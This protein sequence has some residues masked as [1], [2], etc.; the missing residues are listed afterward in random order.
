MTLVKSITKRYTTSTPKAYLE[1]IG[2]YSERNLFEIYGNTPI[3]RDHEVT[4]LTFQERDKNPTISQLHCTILDDEDSFSLRDEDSTNG[5][6]LNGKKLEPLAPERLHDGDV[7]EIGQLERGGIKF[8]FSLAKPEE[9]GL[10]D[11]RDF[12]QREDDIPYEEGVTK[13]RR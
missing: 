11:E 9:N 6:Y 13:R 1:V 3:G 4:E 12:D 10:S 8:R 2:G 7:I 5:T